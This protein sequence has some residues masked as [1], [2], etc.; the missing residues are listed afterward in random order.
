MNCII[1]WLVIEGDKVWYLVEYNTQSPLTLIINC[2]IIQYNPIIGINR[3]VVI[4]I[5]ISNTNLFSPNHRNKV[6]FIIHILYIPIDNPLIFINYYRS[7]SSMTPHVIDSY[8]K[9]NIW[10]FQSSITYIIDGVSLNNTL[11]QYYTFEQTNS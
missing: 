8:I 2:Y 10:L 4:A 1:Y 3:I 7:A 9:S 11:Q 6:N 5:T